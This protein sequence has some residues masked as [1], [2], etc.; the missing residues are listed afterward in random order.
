MKRIH[1]EL[2]CMHLPPDVRGSNGIDWGKYATK[3][4]K[5]TSKGSGRP[6]RRIKA[7]VGSDGVGSLGAGRNTSVA[8]S[9]R[10]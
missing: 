10:G 4:T 3:R 5:E 7:V 1:V 2:H 8:G 9:E 6:A